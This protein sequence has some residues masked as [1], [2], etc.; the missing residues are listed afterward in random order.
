MCEHIKSFLD[1]GLEFWEAYTEIETEYLSDVSVDERVAYA[2]LMRSAT[3]ST[4]PLYKTYAGD[5]GGIL[6]L[7]NS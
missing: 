3:T 7:I 2:N 1:R 6:Y 5:D 4:C